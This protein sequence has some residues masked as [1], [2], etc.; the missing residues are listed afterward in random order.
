MDD[1]E[2]D[3][4]IISKRNFIISQESDPNQSMDAATETQMLQDELKRAKLDVQAY[5]TTIT[6]LQQTLRAMEKTI[7]ELRSMESLAPTKSHQKQT[8]DHM[9]IHHS[10][11]PSTDMDPCIQKQR[12][13]PKYS[14]TVSPN[15]SNSFNLTGTSAKPST[16]PGTTTSC[17]EVILAPDAP[18]SLYKGTSTS[19]L[20]RSYFSPSGSSRVFVYDHEA[21]AWSELP[22]CPT[23]YFSLVTVNGLVTAVGG[24]VGGD[25]KQPTNILL[26]LLSSPSSLSDC[27]EDSCP[28]S[29]KAR[30]DD[31]DPTSNLRWSEHFP[32]MPTNRGYPAAV[33]HNHSLIVAGG[34]TTWLR[35]SFL[36]T[37]E[38]LNTVALQ[39]YTV[40]SLPVPLRGSTAAV[41]ISQQP[42]DS[43]LYLLGGWDKTGNSVHACSLR[44]LLS[45]AIPYD[46]KDTLSSATN[47]PCSCCWKT[48]APAPFSDCSCVSLRNQLFVFGG[49][50]WTGE[51]SEYVYAYHEPANQWMC[52]GK[53]SVGR[54]H[55]LVAKLADDC[56]AV[57]VGGMTKGPHVTTCCEVVQLLL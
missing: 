27:N 22:E 24:W 34:D 23:T 8:N 3:L 55:P 26:S 39:W 54:S 9:D 40:S 47:I 29:K 43:T 1:V 38:V 44:R 15:T 25:R 32:P 28:E 33:Y 53:I 46:P 35:E 19:Y 51:G 4:L 52:V 48:V 12:R 31:A 7:Q 21:V 20:C 10:V 41:S 5:S 45:T 36:T 37:V 30:L 18:I 50:R 13:S 11:G 2:K 49:R 17:F 16:K 6:S 57:V 14:T 42:L 56:R